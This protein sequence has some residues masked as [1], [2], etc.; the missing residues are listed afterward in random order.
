M[1]KIELTLIFLI[2]MVGISFGQSEQKEVLLLGTMHGVPKILKNS[3]RPL[4]KFI[5][6]AS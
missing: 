3:Y 4:Y 5:S 6:D 2:G 1:R